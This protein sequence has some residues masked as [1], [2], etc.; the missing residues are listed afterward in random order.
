[1]KRVLGGLVAIFFCVSAAL[2]GVAYPEFGGTPCEEESAKIAASPNFSDGAFTNLEP[3]HIPI[4]KNLTAFQYSSDFKSPKTAV[5]VAKYTPLHASELQ[6][7]HLRVTWLGHSTIL[8][9]ID[10]RRFLI[11]PIFEQRASPFHFVGPS[12]WY[13]APM[14]EDEIPPLD[15]ILI[16]H[17]HYDHLS[18]DAI[19]QLQ[20]RNT[21]FYVPLGL[22]GRL[23]SWGVPSE[24][25]NVGD[26]WDSFSI[27]NI[28]L[29]LVPARHA[30][31]RGLTDYLSTLWCGFAIN[32]PH[33]RI[34]YSGDTGWTSAFREIGERLGPFDIAL[35]EAGAYHE[36]WPDWHL[37]PE[38]AVQGALDAQAHLLVP[39]HWGRFTMAFHGWTEPAERIRVASGA[40][41]LPVHF[42]LPGETFVHG[43]TIRT[44]PWWPNVPWLTADEHAVV[45]T[46]D[47]DP[48]N[49]V[50]LEF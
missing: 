10:G 26:W 31:G 50:E 36:A 32:G 16:S 25:I 6:K 9:E 21:P 49:P 5:S 33:H 11:D 4:W 1:M 47:G 43:R 15:G 19:E 42:P 18:K 41:R 27:G 3:M 22:G 44:A 38:M 48:A 2:Y 23:E 30:S 40:A 46:L 13:P 8:L 14:P 24:R 39:V 17:D 12:P 20:G 35:M 29:T 45:G 28:T 34:Y 7:N 37:G